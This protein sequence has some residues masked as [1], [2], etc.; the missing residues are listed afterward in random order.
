M[1]KSLCAQCEKRWRDCKCTGGQAEA[2]RR[3]KAFMDRVRAGLLDSSQHDDRL[4]ST[5]ALSEESSR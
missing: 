1:P 5:G 3:D 2:R 4:P